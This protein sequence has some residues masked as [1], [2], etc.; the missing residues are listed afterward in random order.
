MMKHLLGEDAATLV[1]VEVIFGAKK[2]VDNCNGSGSDD[3]AP[4]V[5]DTLIGLRKK[6]K[7]ESVTVGFGTTNIQF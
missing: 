3:T 6:R 5:G 2:G 4:G 7:S 1:G